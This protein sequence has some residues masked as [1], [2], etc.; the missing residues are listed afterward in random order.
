MVCVRRL[1]GRFSLRH[2]GGMIAMLFSVLS[3][4]RKGTPKE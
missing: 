1:E 4:E 2:M 3:A